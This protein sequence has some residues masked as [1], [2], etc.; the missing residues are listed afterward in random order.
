MDQSSDYTGFCRGGPYHDQPLTT[1]T[2][3]TA[4]FTLGEYT[5]VYIWCHEYHAYFWTGTGPEHYSYF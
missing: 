1:E 5:G 2:G 3:L 4:R